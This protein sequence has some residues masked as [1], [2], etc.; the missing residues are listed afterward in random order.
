MPSSRRQI[1]TTGARVSETA[2]LKLQAVGPGGHAEL[3][4]GTWHHAGSLSGNWITQFAINNGADEIH[5]IGM[6]GY[7]STE[8]Q[9]VSDHWDGAPGPPRGQFINERCARPFL[10]SCLDLCPNVHFVMYGKPRIQLAGE[11]LEM[12]Q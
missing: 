9:V 3:V 1:S 11:N 8:S 4:R 10:Q 12:V 6:E 7:A 5:W 2:D